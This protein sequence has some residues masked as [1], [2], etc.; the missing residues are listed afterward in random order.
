MARQLLRLRKTIKYLFGQPS[1]VTSVSFFVS[2]PSAHGMDLAK[3][4]VS[5]IRDQRSGLIFAL[6][7]IV[8]DDTFAQCPVTCTQ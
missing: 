5:K 8:D 6:L 7:Q 3:F 4:L 1:Y 2:K